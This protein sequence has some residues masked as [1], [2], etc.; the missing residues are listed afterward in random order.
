MPDGTRQVLLFAKNIPLQWPTPYVFSSP[1]ALAKGT[2]LSVIEHFTISPV[3][4]GRD[5]AVTFSAYAGAPLA[6]EPSVPE[7]PGAHSPEALTAR[8]FRL[9][10]TVKS[11]D[12]TDK[13][14]VIQ[15]GDIPGLMGAMTMSYDVGKHED[16]Q[17]LKAGDEIQSD[18]IVN[19]T[20]T[21]LENIK[22]TPKSK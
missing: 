2:E 20:S 7:P 14:L 6:T 3:D 4:S 10:G 22:V 11:V 17:K 9:K 16:L 19:A 15:H 12:A 18:V 1:V 21:Y 13:Q 8:H 5:A